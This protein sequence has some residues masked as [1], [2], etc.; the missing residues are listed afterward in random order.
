L[1]DLFYQ[2]DGMMPVIFAIETEMNDEE[3]ENY[4]SCKDSV[5]LDIDAS[6]VTL[7]NQMDGPLPDLPKELELLKLLN[8]IKNKMMDNYDKVYPDGNIPEEYCH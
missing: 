7:S 1:K 5:I 2:L 4:L 6:H 8:R 3:Y